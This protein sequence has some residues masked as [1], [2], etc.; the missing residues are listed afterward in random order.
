L[1]KGDRLLIT[2]E[3][4]R[5]LKVLDTDVA[6]RVGNAKAEWTEINALDLGGVTSLSLETPNGEVDGENVAFTFTGP[7]ILVFR[8]GVMERRLGSIATNVFTFNTPPE[9]GDNIE[10]LV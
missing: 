2:K 9:M 10:G 3:M 1:P 8:N 6:G 5:Y 4:P 7:P